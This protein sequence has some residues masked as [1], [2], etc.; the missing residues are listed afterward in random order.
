[1]KQILILTSW[2]DSKQTYD[3]ELIPNTYQ[4]FGSLAMSIM[5][6]GQVILHYLKITVQ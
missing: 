1:M 6:Y 4:R 2:P 3:E 5:A